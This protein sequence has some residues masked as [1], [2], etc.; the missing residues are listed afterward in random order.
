MALRYKE[1]QK[2]KLV[3][4]GYMKSQYEHHG[5]DV[6]TIVRAVPENEWLNGPLVPEYEVKQGSHTF[7]VPEYSI[8]GKG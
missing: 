2:V 4:T 3:S 8:G 5:D 7:V 6:V 1:G